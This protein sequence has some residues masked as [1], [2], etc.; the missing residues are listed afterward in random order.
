MRVRVIVLVIVGVALGACKDLT[1]GE[2]TP[3]V[4]GV[5]AG[6]FPGDATMTLL[7]S[8]EANQVIGSGFLS[9][10]MVIG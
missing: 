10:Q 2:A 1:F 4:S 3:G 5:W 6:E 7:L 8:Q 9:T